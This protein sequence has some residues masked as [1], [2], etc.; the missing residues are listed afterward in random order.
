MLDDD[1][2]RTDAKYD[3]C[4]VRTRAAR[5]LA[6]RSVQPHE[7]WLQRNRRL[8]LKTLSFV[9]NR[10]MLGF[11]FLIVTILFQAMG[12]CM[13]E[14]FGTVSDANCFRTFFQKKQ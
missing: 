8:L 1:A 7:P 5:K 13:S 12:V 4:K 6:R 2:D 14:R 10:N 3:N 9:V 11:G